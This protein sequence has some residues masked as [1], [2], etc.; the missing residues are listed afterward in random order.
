M[1][2]CVNTSEMALHMQLTTASVHR[3]ALLCNFSSQAAGN[4]VICVF[5]RRTVYSDTENCKRKKKRLLFPIVW[6]IAQDVIDRLFPRISATRCRYC[7][8]AAAVCKCQHCSLVEVAPWCRGAWARKRRK[9]GDV[10][11]SAV[12]LAGCAWKVSLRWVCAS[13]AAE[14]AVV[15]WFMTNMLPIPTWVVKLTKKNARCSVFK[16]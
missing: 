12:S 7:G 16:F 15:T 6:H 9:R 5:L 11:L 3:T 8:T 4:R 2:C 1:S 13:A 10:R 14:P